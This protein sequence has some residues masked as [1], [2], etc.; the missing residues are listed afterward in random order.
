MCTLKSKNSLGPRA[1]HG[2][3]GANGTAEGG[4]LVRAA[5]GHDL[6]PWLG[7]QSR[8]VRFSNFTNYDVVLGRIL[9]DDSHIAVATKGD[10]VEAQTGL[11]DL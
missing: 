8:R 6:R 11:G 9:L 4:D 10:S 5:G 3:V 1:S 2:G 7:L